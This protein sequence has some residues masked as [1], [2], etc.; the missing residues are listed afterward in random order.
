MPGSRS[1]VA[2]G[3]ALPFSALLGMLLFL[4][5]IAPVF[6]DGPEREDVYIGVLA[7]RGPERTLVRWAPTADYLT[8]Q[9]PGFRF[10]ISPIGFQ[11]IYA[12]AQDS[13]VDFILANSGIYVELESRYGVGRIVTLRNLGAGRY[14]YTRF[15]GVLFTRADRDDIEEISDLAGLRLAAVEKNSFGGFLAGQRELQENGLALNDLGELHF[16]GTHDAVVYAVRDG[17]VDA[18]TIRTDTLERMALEGKIRLDD[19]RIIAPKSYPDFQYR[20]SSRLYPEWPLAKLRH[21]DEELSDRVA[22]ALLAMPADSPA[23][24]AGQNAGWSVPLNYQPVHELMKTLRVG[25]YESL[26]QVT[27]IEALRQHWQWGV[28]AAAFLLLLGLA[29]AYVATLNRRLRRVD[30]ELREARDNLAQRV[31]E[32]T[33]ELEESHR[34]L[35]LVYRDWNDAFDAIQDPIFIHDR[36]LRIVHANPA[37]VERAG[38]PAEAIEGQ[39]YWRVFPVLDKPLPECSDFPEHVHVEG[40]EIELEGGEVFVSRSFGIKSPDG[41]FRHA[42][43][44][45]EDVTAERRAERRRR[46][47]S[48]AV[49]QAREGVLVLSRGRDVVYCNRAF[50][51]LAGKAPDAISGRPIEHLLP[52]LGATIWHDVETGEGWDGEVMLPLADG[53]ELVIHASLSA[54]RS[55][56]G[57]D[58]GFVLTALDLSELKEAE[59]QLRYRIAYE[60]VIG[61]IAGAFVAVNGTLD[62]EIHRALQRI[63]EFVGADRAYLFRI[64]GEQKLITDSHEWTREGLPAHGEQPQAISL[65][66]FPWFRR[67]L[68]AQETIQI[69]DVSALPED[70]RAEREYL[71]SLD[72]SAT[73]TVPVTHGGGLAGFIGF[74]RVG[75]GRAS[76]IPEDIR[77]LRTAG[78][79]IANALRRRQAEEAVRRSQA[80]LAEAQRIAHLGNWDWNIIT[81]ELFWSDEIY[82]TFGIEPQQFGATYDAFLGYVHPDD[83][84]HVIDSVNA[85]VEGRTLYEIDHRIVPADG[86]E[87]VVHEIGRVTYDDGGRAIRMIGTVQDV[88]EARR[89]ETEMKRLNRA[90]RT[91]SRGNTTLVHARD[92]NQLLH[93]VCRVLVETG[94]YRLAWVGYPQSDESKTVRPVAHAGFEA[95][96]LKAVQITWAEDEHGLGPTGTAVREGEVVVARDIGSDPH[97]AP[98]REE[99]LER[100]YVSVIALPLVT[101]GESLGVLT[102][103]AV[104]PNAFDEQ[105][106]ALLTE[107]AGDLAYGIRAL[108]NREERDRAEA[109]SKESERRYHDLFDTA[110]AG[111]A[112]ISATDGRLLQCNPAFSRILGY[113]REQL[114]GK[115]VTELYADNPDGRPR[116]REVFERFVQGEGV[117]DAELQ[118]LRADGKSVWVSLTVEPVWDENGNVIESRSSIIDISE[119]K[120]AEAD[121]HHFAERL[122]SSLLQTIQAI[123]LTIE[124]RDPYTSGHQQRVAELAVAIGE[125][126]GLSQHRIEGLRLGALIHD[127]GKVYVPTEILNRPGRLD[128]AQ[129]LLIRSHPQVGYDIVK[130][131][132]FPWPLAKMVAQHHER[133]DG[134]G[135]PQGLKGDDILFESRIL[136]VADVVEA[137][138]SHRPYRPALPLETAMEEIESHQSDWFDPSVTEACLRLFREDGFRWTGKA[139]EPGQPKPSSESQ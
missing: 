133:L 13:E 14:A 60:S 81:N 10:H 20:V 6:A 22:A 54:I 139:L 138:A 79:I 97:F 87:K 72:V 62:R 16:A 119:R 21:T 56:G 51:G 128:D 49:E 70:A 7:K 68:L 44:I 84:Q 103:D 27:L 29:N 91:L 19:F 120:L 75:Q 50:A 8:E 95:G 82:R 35:A 106:V 116:A 46:T 132:D 94:G 36:D 2:A 17:E 71:S 117:R 126:L 18:G 137:M 129:F 55:R 105:E 109:A 42:I 121:R 64:S 43:H 125:K 39:F 12:A 113:D 69:P 45:L 61:A 123:A 127:I 65:E 5:V 28:T 67:Q 130:G 136:A 53:G 89:A 134:S 74:D 63:G 96:Y 38:L 92:E 76:W 104:E 85:A 80:S 90:L 59:R 11:Q 115:N 37:Y 32:R 73:V 26:G 25:P 110:P 131:I 112:S 101:G 88:T 3:V 47:L 4:L 34:R 30:L 107:L 102:I 41:V 124:K 78:E 52:G 66:R 111:Y 15:G 77:L 98:W 57:A 31:E 135:Y 99:A 9:I 58:S 100:G 24:K 40:D 118:M 23:A 33:A 108:R 93:D 48:R 1:S 83:R 86:P 114:C 122:E